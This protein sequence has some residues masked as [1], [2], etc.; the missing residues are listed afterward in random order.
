MAG[1]PRETMAMPSWAQ[2][3]RECNTGGASALRMEKAQH[4]MT[5]VTMC[6]ALLEYSM[7]HGPCE[8]TVVEQK[9]QGFCRLQQ[10]NGSCFRLLS[11]CLQGQQLLNTY[12][13]ERN[14]AKKGGNPFLH[15]HTGT[16]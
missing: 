13:R 15:T 3:R 1:P 10:T 7:L 14:Y 16:H 2:S 6:S 11:E 12:R 4:A 5:Q 9:Q 8:S